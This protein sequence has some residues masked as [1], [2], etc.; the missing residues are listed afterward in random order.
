MREL[1]GTVA[2]LAALAALAV[3]GG[4]GDEPVPPEADVPPSSDV[5]VDV[6]DAAEGSVM[7]PIGSEDCPGDQNDLHFASGARCL[8]VPPSVTELACSADWSPTESGG[9]APERPPNECAA[10][11]FPILGAGCVQV[12][13]CEPLTDEQIRRLFGETSATV[14]R[15]SPGELAE[16]IVEAEPG[17]ILA[18]GAG[19]FVG[20]F[21][22]S[23]LNVVGVCASETVVR[24]EEPSTGI[25]AMN[26]S[27]GFTEI[28]DLSVSGNAIGIWVSSGGRAHLQNVE[29]HSARRVGIRVAGGGAATLERVWVHDMLPSFED[30][31][32]GRGIQV[33]SE[34]SAVL[35]DVTVQRVRDI[36]VVAIDSGAVVE[37]YNLAVDTVTENEDPSAPGNGVQAFA[38][39]ASVIGVGL[40]IWD[41][42]SAALVSS[43]GVV[44]VEDVYIEGLSVPGT[45]ETEV[46]GA[47][48]SIGTATLSARRVTVLDVEGPALQVDA[49]AEVELSSWRVS[50]I[51]GPLVF[52]DE[53][54]IAI[55]SDTIAEVPKVLEALNGAEITFRNSQLVAQ[56][57]DVA[58]D[59]STAST[60]TLHQCSLTAAGRA[61]NVIGSTL[62]AEDVVIEASQG[63]S[64]SGS[65]TWSRTA[66]VVRGEGL[67]VLGLFN[68]T[69]LEISA[70]VEPVFSI[71]RGR[72]ELGQSYLGGGI[73]LVDGEYL[74]RDSVLDASERAV[75][76]RA[77]ELIVERVAVVGSDVA[78]VVNDGELV[79]EA[80][81]LERV[82]AEQQ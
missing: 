10:G 64:L 66:L 38:N 21:D 77:G 9:C 33:S 42:Q 23:E 73:E 47:I 52:A 58:L 25:G 76:I 56:D 17:D 51:E 55:I 40:A 70:G 50:E 44:D 80:G 59:V 13:S 30:D 53:L 54:G 31:S 27:R 24:S 20:Q 19:E 14:W 5:G 48:R 67:E 3:L 57:D 29:V 15:V 41:T 43:G 36:G 35:Q 62:D 8:P 32:F 7:R 22:V 11:H 69:D 28:R 81:V 2:L 61:A 6:Q 65:G 16:T 79:D 82:G 1:L 60:V 18:L 74:I 49:H 63:V 45:F 71:A 37:F 39:A 46:R 68:G 4:C 34:S 75:E 78:V 12:S 72:G 26:A